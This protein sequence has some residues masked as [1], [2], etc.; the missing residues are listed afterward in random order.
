MQQT[1]GAKSLKIPH[2]TYATYI[3]KL[4]NSCIAQKQLMNQNEKK[5]PQV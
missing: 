3:Q 2:Q 4:H 5:T 1:T